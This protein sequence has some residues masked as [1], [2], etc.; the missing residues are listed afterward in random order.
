ML[1]GLDW[2]V[3]DKVRIFGDVPANLTV[4]YAAGSQLNAGLDVAANFGS[5]RFGPGNHYVRYR[6]FIAGL[7]AEYYVQPRVALR[8]TAGYS[9]VRNLEIYREHDRV[10]GILDF[11]NLGTAPLPI[12]PPITT[13]LVLRL[14]LSFRIPTP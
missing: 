5:Y 6:T 2:R 11:A 7:F 13:G 8:A 12:S 10:S 9:L 1:G 3:A 4:S 14:A